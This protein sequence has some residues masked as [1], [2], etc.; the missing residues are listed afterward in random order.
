MYNFNTD[1]YPLDDPTLDYPYQDNTY[2]PIPHPRPHSDS[3]RPTTPAHLSNIFSH[4]PIYPSTRRADPSPSADSSVLDY[5]P[6]TPQHLF[7]TPSELLSN[8]NHPQHSAHR[9]IVDSCPYIPSPPPPQ[10]SRQHSPDDTT[11]STPPISNAVNKT[12]SQR[13]ARQ[14]AIA[15]E[16]GFTPTDPYVSRMS[17]PSPLTT[18]PHQR[19]HLV[20]REKTPLSRMFGAIRPL[21]PRTAQTRPD[22][23][24]G[25]GTC[26]HIPRAVLTQHTHSPRAHA[27]HK[28]DPPRRHSCRGTSGRPEYSCTFSLCVLTLLDLVSRF[29]S[30]GRRCT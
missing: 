8:I 11:T 15:E 14:R 28:Q 16:I 24:P 9:D 7:P 3:A 29:V 10:T 18:S 26:I 27:E 5:Y 22:R 20:P 6:A 1:L 12:E 30:P 25:A 13:K 17:F 23:S 2:L 4:Q 21:P 19:H